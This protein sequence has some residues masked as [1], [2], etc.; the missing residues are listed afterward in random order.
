MSSVAIRVRNLVKEFEVYEKPADLAIEI[1]TRRKRHRTFRALDDVNFEVKQGQVLGIIGPNG[2][3]KSTLLKIITGV[4]DANAGC[5]DVSGRVTAILELGLGFNPEHSG[6][7]NIFLSGLLYGMSRE[8]IE[9]KLE[10]IIDF[11]G[12]RPFIDQPVK[13]Y[14]SGMH[15]RLAFSIATAV[16]PEILI[17]DEALAAGDSMFVQKCM[18]RIRQLCSGGRTVLLVSHGTGLLAQLC[19]EVMWIEAGRVKMFGP[20]LKVVQ[21]YDLAAHQG[22]DSESWIETV[23]DTDL[24]QEEAHGPAK[25]GEIR[26]EA[27]AALPVAGDPNADAASHSTADLTETEVAVLERSADASA[28]APL[29]P[30]AVTGVASAFGADPRTGAQDTEVS[31]AETGKSV[32]RRGPIFIDSVT[33]LNHE[34]Q[35]STNLTTARPFYLRIAYRCR[36]ELPEETLGVALSVNRIG[37][38]EPVFQWYT[39][40]LRPDE[41]REIYDL[42]PFRARPARRGVIELKFPYAPLRQDEYILSI[43]L[44][45]NAP[46]NWEFYEYRHFFYPFQVMDASL[47]VGAPIFFEP[48]VVEYTELEDMSESGAK[49]TAPASETDAGPVLPDGTLNSEIRRVCMV[50]GRYPEGWPRH[51]KCPC[52]GKGDLKFLFSKFGLAHDQCTECEFVCM[53]PYPSDEMVKKIYSGQYYTNFREHYEAHYLR[54]HGEHSLVA[55]PA[56]LLEAMIER[57]TRGRNRGAWLDVGGGL[58]TVADLIQTRRPGWHVTLNEF[59]PRSIELAQEI[60]G[61]AAVSGDARELAASGCKFDVIS[62][63][64]VLE[65]IPDPASFIAAYAQL[66]TPSGLLVLMLPHFTHLNAAVSRASSPNATPPF[67]VSL[68]RSSNLERVLNRTGYFEDVKIDQSGPAAFSLLHHYDFGEYW[69]ILAPTAQRPV[70]ETIKVADYPLEMAVGLNALSEAD[71]AVHEHFAQTD[72]RLYLTAFARRRAG[73]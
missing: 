14:S 52:C 65:H 44:L 63:I 17:I 10:G 38:L 67:H 3:G 71:E 8:E 31:Q 16:D 28:P 4:L 68:F 51:E 30:V 9:R 22:A 24:V 49:G 55:A 56:E 20:A 58:G 19:Q 43:G 1:F 57:A 5:V 21:A 15:S 64:M 66:L 41:T 54:E 13:T 50:E 27:S 61:L 72:G 23:E 39:Q 32:F 46:G 12:L 60:Y 47:S 18:R 35:P 36:G 69:D 42:A 34:R 37:N 33:M 25:A 2:A 59:N 45:P 7:D 26:D 62:A 48:S 11:S 29:P 53:N 40:F 6:R 73:K 70:P